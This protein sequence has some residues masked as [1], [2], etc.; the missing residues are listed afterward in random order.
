MHWRIA[1]FCVA[2]AFPALAAA[3]P[4]GSDLPHFWHE[5][6]KYV[7]LRDLAV[8]Y[9]MELTGPTAQRITLQNRAHTLI[10]KTDSREVQVDGIL[11]WLHAPMTLIRNR[12]S[13]REVDARIV[14]DPLLRPARHLQSVGHRTVVIDPGHGGQDT[15]AKGRHGVEEKRVVLDLSR[16]LRAH[17]VNAGVR[18]RM[19]R[20]SDRFVELDERSR[21][22]ARW[23]ADLFVSIHLNSAATP[24]PSGVETFVL[25][26]AGYESTAGGLSNLSQPGNRFESANGV[27][28]FQIQRAIVTRLGSADRGVKRSRFIVLKN[29]PCPAVLVE[30]AFVSNPAEEAKLLVEAHREAMAECLARGVL[31]YLNLVRR[32]QAQAEAK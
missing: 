29:A 16:R 9:G 10:F 4:R 3:N 30:C 19:T 8:A 25:A 31:N 12:W 21:L 22:A 18:V 15:G 17:L 5:K 28:A 1:I 24:G 13:I 6:E 11:V 32:A 14:V 7:A 26:A 27:A 2:L 23:G 20:E